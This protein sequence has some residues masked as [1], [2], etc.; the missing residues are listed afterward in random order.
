[1]I[2]VHSSST[3]FGSFNPC[4][5]VEGQREV[6]KFGSRSKALDVLIKVSL[7]FRQ[8]GLGILQPDGP[9]WTGVIAQLETQSGPAFNSPEPTRYGGTCL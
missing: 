3:L 6:G 8:P 1:M 9:L 2:L 4:R 7:L 5:S